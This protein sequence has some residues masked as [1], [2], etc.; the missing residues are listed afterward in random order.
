MVAYLELELEVSMIS[1]GRLG[2]FARLGGRGVLDGE[3]ARARSR[4]QGEI[5]MARSV[6]QGPTV[7]SGTACSYTVY[8]TVLPC[9]PRS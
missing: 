1:L 4:E 3:T 9:R 2:A 7:S 5:P 8:Y 6:A